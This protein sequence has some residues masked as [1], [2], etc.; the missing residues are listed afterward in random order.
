MEF[1]LIDGRH[2]GGLFQKS[3]KI[4]YRKVTDTLKRVINAGLTN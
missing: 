1:N 2:D 4:G 3:L